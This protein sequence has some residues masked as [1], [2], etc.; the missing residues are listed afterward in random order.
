MLQTLQVGPHLK[1]AADQSADGDWFRRGAKPQV[2][3]KYDKAKQ[4]RIKGRVNG[5]WRMRCIGRLDP[6]RL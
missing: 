6:G 2:A 5:P 1:T 3:K 4:R